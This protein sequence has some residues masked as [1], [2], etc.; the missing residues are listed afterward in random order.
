L[1]AYFVKRAR[2]LSTRI[3]RVH[4]CGNDRRCMLS[5][6][7][8]LHRLTRFMPFV[9]IAPTKQRIN[10]HVERDHNTQTH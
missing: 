9:L 3:W 1:I 4:P 8:C 2:G 5:A 7:C 6:V 10:A